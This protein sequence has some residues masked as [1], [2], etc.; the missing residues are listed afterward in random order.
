MALTS[1]LVAAGQQGRGCPENTARM[2]SIHGGKVELVEKTEGKVKAK[3][4]WV[5]NR[6]TVNWRFS[7][8]GSGHVCSVEK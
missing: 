5:K 4:R 6:W 3:V 7:T 1:L 8:V 2:W